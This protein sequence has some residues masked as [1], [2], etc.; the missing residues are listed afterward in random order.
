MIPFVLYWSGFRGENGHVDL[1]EVKMRSFGV[2][3]LMF[4]VFFFCSVCVGQ[5]G[6]DSPVIQSGVGSENS[7]LPAVPYIAEVTGSDVYVRSGHSMSSYYCSKIDSPARVIV[8]DHKYGWSK[9]KPPTGSFSWISKSF[10]SKD[11]NTPDY[12]V[13]TG[14]SVRVWAGAGHIKPMHSH[15]LQTQLNEGDVVTLMGEDSGDYYKIVPP[16]GAHLWISSRFLKY[17]GPMAKDPITVPG[18]VEKEVTMPS[19]GDAVGDAAVEAVV[20]RPAVASDVVPVRVAVKD[21]AVKRVVTEA[22]RLLVYHELAK[23]IDAELVKAMSA[24]SYVKI[25]E[26]LKEIASDPVSG[27]AGDYAKFQLGRIESIEL[28]ISAGAE[29]D[30]QAMNLAKLREQIKKNRQSK[31]ADI[32]DTGKFTA[33]G[34]FRQSHVYT[35]KALGKRY[36]IVDDS[37]KIVCYAVAGANF[38]KTDLSKFLHRKVGIKGKVKS[39]KQSPSVLIEFTSIVEIK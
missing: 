2:L 3:F 19:V 4:S 5:E 7:D 22:E 15:S 37:G 34:K 11:E 13:V 38:A 1:G 10:V 21:A 23:Q 35:S 24:Q 31:L 18:V 20:E 28:A 30:R 33:A 9:I 14:D 32:G 12:G 8:T 17:I 6:K 25:K 26:G 27:K 16:T 29:V 39:D 36:L